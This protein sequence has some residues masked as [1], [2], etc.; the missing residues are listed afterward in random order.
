MP[1]IKRAGS[2]GARSMFYRRFYNLNKIR[3]SSYLIISRVYK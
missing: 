1:N 3:R 2:I